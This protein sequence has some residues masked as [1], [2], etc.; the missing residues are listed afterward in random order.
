MNGIARLTTTSG[1]SNAPHDEILGKSIWGACRAGFLRRT[2][3]RI[4]VVDELDPQ[5]K[6]ATEVNLDDSSRLKC[7][8]VEPGRNSRD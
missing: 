8:R 7:Y 6:P 2:E 5:P 4:K 1:G 3:M